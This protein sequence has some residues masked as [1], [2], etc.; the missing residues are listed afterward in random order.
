[1]K[2]ILKVL[3]L[4][5][6]IITI[7]QIN[8]MYALYKSEVEEESSV[9]IGNWIL[10]VDGEEI[11]KGV[12][13]ELFTLSKRYLHYEDSDLIDENKNAPGRG[14]YFDLTIDASSCSVS[15]EYQIDIVTSGI[16]ADVEIEQIENYI[17][18]SNGNK[19]KENNNC[20]VEG[21]TIKGIFKFEDSR[22]Y[23]NNIR[24]HLKWKNNEEKNNSDSA[25]G[26]K[27]N[28][29]L[30]IPMQAKFKQYLGEE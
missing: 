3:F 20:S 18:D 16:D 22:S 5:M 28:A 15:V 30:T 6:L 29:L 21:E 9:T 12:E 17:A 24:V 11:T 7:I 19:I 4:I 26:T 10:K 8:Q 1:M 25:L 14:F 27:E 13:S 2:K 23:R